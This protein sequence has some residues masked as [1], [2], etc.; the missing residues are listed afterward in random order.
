[1]GPVVRSHEYW[2]RWSL[3]HDWEGRYIAVLQGDE[4]V[5][6]F[7]ICGGGASCDEIGWCDEMT[8]SREQTFHAAAS[9]TSGQGSKTLTFWLDRNDRAAIAAL[10]RLFGPAEPSC[11]NP[12]G[13]RVSDDDIVPW[14]PENWPDG[15]GYLVK[16]LNPGPGILADVRSTDA[17]T[18]VMDQ[19][20]WTTFNGD[21]M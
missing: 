14:L 10:H 6:Y 4:H 15:F 1:L 18:Q 21:W 8:G 20:H 16:Y 12:V 17:L 7:H 19:H 3:T 13:Q 2:R 11:Y 9:W 5:G